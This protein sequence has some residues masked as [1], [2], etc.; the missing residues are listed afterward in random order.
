MMAVATGILLQQLSTDESIRSPIHHCIEIRK[1]S[2]HGNGNSSV[3]L[4][5]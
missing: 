1:L 4:G 5:I 2:P 3:N